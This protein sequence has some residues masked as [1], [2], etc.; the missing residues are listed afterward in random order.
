[1]LALATTNMAGAVLFAAVYA[2][3]GARLMSHGAF[4]A[5]LVI[6]FVLVTTLWIRVESRHCTLGPGGRIGRIGAG[7]FLGPIMTLVLICLA[8]IVAVNVVGG[9]VAVARGVLSERRQIE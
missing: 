2:T 8:L 3:A 9:L 5:C 6:I 1:M 7:R 4:L